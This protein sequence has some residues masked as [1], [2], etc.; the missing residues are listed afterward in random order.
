MERISCGMAVVTTSSTMTR[1]A[2]QHYLGHRNIQHPTRYK[3]ERGG[4]SLACAPSRGT[5]TKAIHLNII[6]APCVVAS[7]RETRNA[8]AT[9]SAARIG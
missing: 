2:L 3:T 4:L 5:C 6:F 1:R 8:R 9:I 7:K